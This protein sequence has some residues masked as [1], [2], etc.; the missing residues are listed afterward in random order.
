VGKYR[1]AALDHSGVNLNIK[2]S[3]EEFD[4]NLVD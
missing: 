2:M 3:I 1:R 4:E